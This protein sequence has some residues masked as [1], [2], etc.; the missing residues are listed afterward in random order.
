[1]TDRDP[2]YADGGWLGPLL[3]VMGVALVILL[4]AL[5]PAKASEQIDN[6]ET[7]AS[8]FCLREPAQCPL[9]EPEAFAPEAKRPFLVFVLNQ[10]ERTTTW[11]S[12]QA[13]FGRNDWWA[14]IVDGKGD[15]EDYAL[16]E[17]KLLQAYGVPLGAMRFLM[18]QMQDQGYHMVL[19]VRF[20]DGSIVDLDSAWREPY[21]ADDTRYWPV[22]A[23]RWGSVLGWAVLSNN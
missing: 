8:S 17:R 6:L 18:V 10:V 13:H 16:T 2:E 20:V 12:D 15:C 22:A 3:L 9:A 7:S 21:A 11:T 4:I 1:M 23:S 14:L 19:E 5:V